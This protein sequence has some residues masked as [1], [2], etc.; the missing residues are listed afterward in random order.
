VA[1]LYALHRLAPNVCLLM[2]KHGSVGPQSS[3]EDMAYND[4]AEKSDNKIV[5][6]DNASFDADQQK[7]H[8]E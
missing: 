8:T 5:E 3:D 7:Y 4:A 1:V 6:I 2:D